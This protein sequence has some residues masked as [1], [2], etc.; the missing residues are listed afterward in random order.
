[1][2]KEHALEILNDVA[3]ARQK[4]SELRNYR[5]MGSIISAWGVVWLLGFGAQ[6]NFPAAAPYVW[7]VGWLGA[8]VWTFTRPPKPEDLR[9]L[10]TWVVAVLCICLIL[11]VTKANQTTAAMIFGLALSAAYAI[12]GVW[13]G[14]RFLVLAALVL[15]SACVGWWLVPQWLYLAL[16]LGGGVA[17]ILGGVWIRRP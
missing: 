3:I 14:K 15:S 5:G 2:D 9:A 4:T 1:M 13:S 17:L 11:V 12:L 7:I 16:A 8:L 6:S 10:T